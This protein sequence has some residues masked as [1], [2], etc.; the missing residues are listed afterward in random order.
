MH[1]CVFAMLPSHNCASHSRKIHFTQTAMTT[2]DILL[3]YN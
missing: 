2:A 1:N 3:I